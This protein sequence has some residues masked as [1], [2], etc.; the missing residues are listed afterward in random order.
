MIC[1]EKR[2]YRGWPNA[3]FL[4]N[5]SVELIV[6]ADVGPR[7]VHYGLRNKENQFHE[8]NDQAGLIGGNDFRLY[9]GHRLW[10]WPEV[11]RTYYPDN[12]PVEIKTMPAGAIFTAPIESNSP[13]THLRRII[14]VS[15]SEQ[16][17]GVTLAHSITN[18]SAAPTELAPWA[19]T[20]LRPGGRAILPFPQ[21]HAMDKQHFQSVSPLTLWSFTD[22]TDSRWIIGSD[23]LQLQQ[24]QKPTGR[25]PEQM[26]GL[27]NLGGWGAYISGNTVFLKRAAIVA[28][29]E[30]PDFGCNFEVFTN[31]EFLELET[32][33][34]VVTL[35]PGESTYHS[36]HWHLF[37]ISAW[38][39][40]EDSIRS[41]ILPLLQRIKGSAPCEAENAHATRVSR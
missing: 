20:V 24:Q 13:G 27:F 1:V 35:Q 5:D 15:L 3:W 31:S 25:F 37:E 34:P 40:S 21:R 4:S 17:S 19:P 30:Y 14:S 28:N 32:L 38:L 18:H 9:G 7:I 6:L 23:F 39:S 41:V 22:F 8:F 11:E 16:G 33:G 26:S 2:A 10:V 36:E 29:A 12:A